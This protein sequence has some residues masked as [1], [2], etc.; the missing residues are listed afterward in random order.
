MK[1]RNHWRLPSDLLARTAAYAK[2]SRISEELVIERAVSDFLFGGRPNDCRKALAK[3]VEMALTRFL[4]EIDSLQ[5]PIASPGRHRTGDLATGTDLPENRWQV[6]VDL[7]VRA[8][9]GAARLR[10]AYDDLVEFALLDLFQEPIEQWSQ[11]DALVSVIEA[12][13]A[14]YLADREPHRPRLQH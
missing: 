6:P 11:P 4:P 1:T 2:R 10:I 7:H 14:H 13:L 8:V 12:A 3:F 9:T 5:V